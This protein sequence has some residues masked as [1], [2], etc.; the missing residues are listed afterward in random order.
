MDKGTV[1]LWR[2]RDDGWFFGFIAPDRPSEREVYFDGRGLADA[3]YVPAKGD[4]VQFGRGPGAKYAKYV[5]LIEIE[6]EGN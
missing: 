5:G 2:Q 1:K 4:R 3:S 6:T